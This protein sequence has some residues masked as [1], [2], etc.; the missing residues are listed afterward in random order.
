MLAATVQLGK[1]L[2]NCT[3]EAFWVIIRWYALSRHQRESLGPCIT[4]DMGARPG[5]LN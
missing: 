4:P 1:E 5:G 2:I 3:E